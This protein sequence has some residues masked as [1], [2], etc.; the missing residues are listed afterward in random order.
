MRLSSLSQANVVECN[1]WTTTLFIN[2]NKNDMCFRSQI[3]QIAKVLLSYMSVYMSHDK[4]F[5]A[6]VY[7]II[8]N[9]L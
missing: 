9:Q 1:K 8:E 7:I 3:R 5:T 2:N 6:E 4:L